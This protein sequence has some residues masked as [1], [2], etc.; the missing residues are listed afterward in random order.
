MCVCSKIL[1]LMRVFE[2]STELGIVFFDE[3]INV[4]GHHC[5]IP[6]FWVGVNNFARIMRLVNS[7]ESRTAM[8]S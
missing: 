6:I 2:L 3:F 1:M 8:V 7:P 5:D 4:L